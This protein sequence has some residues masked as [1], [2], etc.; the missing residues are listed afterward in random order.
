VSKILGTFL[1]LTAGGL[2]FS[3]L[4]FRAFSLNLMVNQS[5]SNKKSFFQGLKTRAGTS[6]QILCILNIPQVTD[7][8]EQNCTVKNPNF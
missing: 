7:N 8:I 3:L 1:P 4:L 6:S 2:V 5:Q